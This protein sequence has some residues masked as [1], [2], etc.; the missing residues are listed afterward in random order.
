MTA[1]ARVE[2]KAV[3]SAV[4]DALHAVQGEQLENGEMPGYLHT[5]PVLYGYV[6]LPI[7]SAYVHDLLAI[8]DPSARAFGNSALEVFTPSARTR[9]RKLA[10]EVRRGIRGFLAW[11][12]DAEGGF[13]QYGRGSSL[14][15]DL[16]TTACS[17]LALVERPQLNALPASRRANR[18]LA[19]A[20]SAPPHAVIERAD[21]LRCI[22]RL[23]GDTAE[24]SSSLLA[25]LSASPSARS[26]SY[27]LDGVAAY[28]LGRLEY[29]HPG[30]LPASHGREL[31]RSL[32]PPA[33]PLA[34]ALS[35]SALL[36]FGGAASD[37]APAYELLRSFGSSH[38]SWP[39]QEFFAPA[40]GSPGLTA[41]FAASAL[42]RAHGAMEQ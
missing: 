14:D 40:C 33:T 39:F 10:A 18:V 7:L 15:A 8:F 24:L 5:G 28:A 4:L 19:L 25:A 3:T 16:D 21:A 22:L 37:I 26:S 1:L 9:V 32:D 12:E 41:A 36:D 35:V 13:R 42:L 38:R 29:E 31:A 27:L 2:P 17:A 23:G 6:R 11:T 34:A 30:V 20:S